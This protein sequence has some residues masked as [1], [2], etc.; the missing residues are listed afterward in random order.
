MSTIQVNT[1]VGNHRQEE[2]PVSELGYRTYKRVRQLY[3]GGQWNPDTN[4][5]WVP[6][7]Y[8]DYT[9]IS[10]S[11]RIRITCHIPHAGLNAAHVISHWIFY[12]NGAEQGRHNMSGNH[13][14][15][16]GTYIWEINSWGTSVGRVGYQMRSYSNDGNET[17]VYTTR[18]WDGGG[19]NQNCYGQL[20]IEEF[21]VG[22]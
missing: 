22:L 3:T 15:D 18:Y 7:M 21:T 12:T 19:S 11:T 4:F 20:S 8:Y 9:P 14:E 10:G 5:N 13:Y 17:R 6:G 2:I 16:A 1:V